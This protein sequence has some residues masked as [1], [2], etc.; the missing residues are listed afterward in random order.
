MYA[1]FMMKIHI[2]NEIQTDY[3]K[4]FKWLFLKVIVLAYQLL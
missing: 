3:L 4:I 1:A 2:F